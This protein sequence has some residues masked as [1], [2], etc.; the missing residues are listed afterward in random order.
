[1]MALVFGA[2]P[3]FAESGPNLI[4]PLV[5]ALAVASAARG[6]PHQVGTMK[7]GAGQLLTLLPR[8]VRIE[9]GYEIDAEDYIRPGFHATP[10]DGDRIVSYEFLRRPHNGWM[11][12]FAY[13]EESRG[14]LARTSDV[15]R[16][17]VEHRF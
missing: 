9:D 7:G 10:I 11:T 13:D 6:T 3:A 4:L 1:M 12:S 8:Q 14:K 17:V 5:T 2:G 15:L 16:F